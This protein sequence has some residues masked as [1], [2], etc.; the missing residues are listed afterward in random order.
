MP[1]PGPNSNWTQ[2]GTTPDGRPIYKDPGGGTYVLNADG[3]IDAQES[4]KY[5]R[6]SNE[7]SFNK[8]VIKPAIGEVRG[9][10]DELGITTP[11][12]P[13]LTQSPEFAALKQAAD[14]FNADYGSTKGRVSET[15]GIDLDTISRL[16][17]AEAGKVPSA[18]EELLRKAGDQNARQ[19]LGLASTLGGANPGMALRSGLAAFSDAGARSAADLAALR[20]NEQATARGQL[21]DATGRAAGRDVAEESGARDAYGRAIAAPFAARVGQQQMDNAA[22]ASNQALWGNVLGGIAK[23]DETTKSN[24][25]PAPAAA[26][27][28]LASLAPQTYT[29][30][31][32]GPNAPPGQRL[33]VMAQDLPRHDV[34]TGPDGKKWISADVIS[35]VLAGMGRLNEKVEGRAPV[36][37]TVAGGAPEYA[38]AMQ[39]LTAPKVDARTY[40]RA[41]TGAPPEPRIPTDDEL[42]AQRRREAARTLLAQMGAL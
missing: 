9:I 14:Q 31:R 20:A 28:F 6:P 7:F 13:D 35:D 12:P 16:R 3:Y 30:D 39:Y 34:T 29:Y 4:A 23:S 33:G 24:I 36:A 2:I 5:P 10:T 11:K 42:E 22:A 18:A 17:D 40:A 27:A 32:P 21:A 38:A 25:A 26:D 8:D 1:G 41:T 15:R 19:A 37:G